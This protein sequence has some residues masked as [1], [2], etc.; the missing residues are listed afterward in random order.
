MR[1]LTILALLISA[2]SAAQSWSL[3]DC[4]DH[5]LSHNI[6]IKQ[7]ELEVQSSEVKL[8]S[9]ESRR[10]PAFAA[11]VSENLSFGR[12]LTADNTYSN[13]NT[14]STSFQLGGELPIFQGFDINNDIKMAKLDLSAATAKLDKVKDDVRVAVMQGYTEILYSRELAKV[15]DIQ[16]HYDAVLLTQIEAKR[17]AG[18]LSDA[19]VSAQR[20]TA[21]QSKLAAIQ[22]ANKLQLDLLAMSQLLELDS[23]EGFDVQSPDVSNIEN[24]LFMKPG[25]IYAEAVGFK[26]IIKS[27]EQMLASAEVGIARAKGGYLPSLKLNGGIGTNFYSSS[28][29]NYGNFSEQLGNNFSQYIGLSLNIPIFSRYNTRNAVRSANIAR[30]NSALQLENARKQLYK[31]IQQAYY[32]A[33]A[34]QA[35]LVSSEESSKAAQYHYELTMEKYSAGKANV[36]QYNDA[37]NSWLRAESEHL[38]ARYECLFQARLLDFYRGEELAF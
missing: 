1:I 15:A 35:K 9:A 16:A 20:A 24:Q 21:A 8:H 13:S 36:S 19:D 38:K 10:L 3:Q 17:D 23:P 7:S 26:P 29:A 34:A 2:T 6:S 27:A 32:N 30:D 28:S 22:A 18:Q 14:T 31:E 12:G 11:S 5:A 4:I 37:K 33:I 25:E